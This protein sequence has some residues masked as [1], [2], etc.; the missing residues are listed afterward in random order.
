MRPTRT[1]SR[2]RRSVLTG[3]APPTCVRRPLPPEGTD[4][5][6]TPQVYGEAIRRLPQENDV[7]L[8]TRA[9]VTALPLYSYD[10]DRGTYRLDEPDTSHHPHR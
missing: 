10:A 5:C 7:V 4:L 3:V 6:R 1:P 9:T 2:S 8:R